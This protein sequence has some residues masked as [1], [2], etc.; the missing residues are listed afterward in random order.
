MK[1]KEEPKQESESEESVWSDIESEDEKPKKKAKKETKKVI[2]VEPKEEPEK[3]PKKESKEEKKIPEAP[4]SIL[5][6][7]AETPLIKAEPKVVKNAQSTL[8]KKE[9]IKA[10][11]A[12]ASISSTN[13]TDNDWI[14]RNLLYENNEFPGWKRIIK[15]LMKSLDGKD[16]LKK[17]FKKCLRKAYEI[18]SSYNK[19]SRKELNKIIDTRI[20]QSKRVRVFADLIQN[21]KSKKE[22]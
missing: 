8:D 14:K 20:E 2:K 10:D 12:N 6:N 17:K 3:E 4:K 18:S 9:K 21:T 22:D 11:I 1:V 19:E 7:S 5:K 15:L 16:A 13:I